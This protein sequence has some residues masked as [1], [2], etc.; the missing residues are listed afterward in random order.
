MAKD[1]GISSGSQRLM[2][3]VIGDDTNLLI[4]ATKHTDHHSLQVLLFIGQIEVKW[5]MTE[6]V[7]ST[8]V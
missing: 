3:L 1:Q 7:H 2:N 6:I 8:K 5:N 4:I